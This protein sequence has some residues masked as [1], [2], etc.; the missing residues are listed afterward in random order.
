MSLNSQQ[1]PESLTLFVP[2]FM[3][4]DPAHRKEKGGHVQI[5][6]TRKKKKKN[7]MGR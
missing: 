7:R 3:S 6:R 4:K 5:K 2:C 1:A